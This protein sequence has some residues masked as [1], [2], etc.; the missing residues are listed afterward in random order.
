MRSRL[1]LCALLG[2]CSPDEPIISASLT[3]AAKPATMAGAL[4]VGVSQVDVHIAN[5]QDGTWTTLFLGKSDVLLA[6]VGTANF[7]GQASVPA[8]NLTQVRIVLD[9]ARLIDGATITTV[10]CPSCTQ[11]GIKLVPGEMIEVHEGGTLDM[12]L[13]F[14]L[15]ASMITRGDT[16]LMFPVIHVDA[17]PPP[18]E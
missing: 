5:D 6:D 14:D 9:G 15:S 10:V 3:A 11:T 12:L 13:T 1:L 8:G 7:L 4:S 16:I 2:A 18:V 17:A